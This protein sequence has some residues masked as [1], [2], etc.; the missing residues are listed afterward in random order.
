[1]LGRSEPALHHATRSLELCQANGIG[2]F[3]LAFAHEALARAYAVAGSPEEARRH[4]A[5]AADAA[6]RVA[7][8]DDRAVVDAALETLP[9]R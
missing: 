7:E 3:D 4:A 9:L 6:T 1:M 5:L 8:D 2:D